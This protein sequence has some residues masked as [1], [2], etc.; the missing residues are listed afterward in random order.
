MNRWPSA[1][2][3]GQ[4]L[5]SGTADAVMPTRS[6]PVELSARARSQ[7]RAVGAKT[8]LAV[9]PFRKVRRVVISSSYT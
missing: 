2:W 1:P 6:V 9:A 5:E 7:P 4:P 8:A 3:S